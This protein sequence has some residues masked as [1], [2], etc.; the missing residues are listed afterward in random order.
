VQWCAA[1][2]VGDV[3]CCSINEEHLDHGNVAVSR[4]VMKQRLTICATAI[5]VDAQN[6]IGIGK[7][8]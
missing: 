8:V 5:N 2:F 4:A 1:K 6:G 7:L 3:H